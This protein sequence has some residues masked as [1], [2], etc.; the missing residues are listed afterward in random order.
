M[1][2]NGLNNDMQREYDEH[3]FELSMNK[4]SFFT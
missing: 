1:D 3:T 2:E 4:I